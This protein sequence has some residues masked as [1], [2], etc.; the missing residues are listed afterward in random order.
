MIGRCPF[1]VL[2][3]RALLFCDSNR[4]SG[5]EEKNITH[6][7]KILLFKSGQLI[8]YVVGTKRLRMAA[9]EIT[10]GAAL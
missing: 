1:P 4:K 5:R 2:G 6:L 9:V 7:R 8:Y 10:E 3:N